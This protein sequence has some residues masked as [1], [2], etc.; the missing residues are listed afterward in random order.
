MFDL[1]KQL[2][3][4]KLK[5]GIVITLALLTLFF[6]VFFAGGI[7]T[8]L[9]PAAELKAQIQDVK[10]LRNGAPV[11]LS[12]IEIGSVKGIQLHPEYGAI[13]TLSVKKS[14][15]PF[16]KKDSHARVLTI[17][18]LGDKYIELSG[19]SPGTGQILPGDTIRGVAQIELKDIM[20]TSVMSIEKLTGFIGRLDTLVARIEKGDGTV[21]K[22]I[23]DPA[24]YDNL[25]DTTKNLSLAIK[26]VKDAR[27]TMKL[28]IE[29]PT[30]YNKMVTAT[31]SV[32]EFGKKLTDGSGTVSKLVDDPTLYNRM[33]SATS[34]IED[35]SKKLTEGSGTLKKLAEDP[36]LYD[37][38]S[39]ASLRLSS[40][41]ERIDKG[42][43]VAGALVKD[44]DLAKELKEIVAEIKELTKD[45][46]DNPK[47]YFKFSVF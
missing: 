12:G 11:W 44:Q 22:F 13:V 37:N 26:D 6:T 27:G 7:E 16:I 45:I 19:G 9:S 39:E 41:L 21:A 31:S 10:G 43:G 33:V 23:S 42:E 8:L 32:E 15:L 35:F 14:A 28:L 46:K 38:L 30:L 18:L 5:V 3:W 29:D 47:R 24:L 20:D 4:S 36:A 2:M 1:K 25:R 17:G 40:I 34:S